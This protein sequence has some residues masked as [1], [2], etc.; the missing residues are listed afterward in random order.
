MMSYGKK[1]CD[2]RRQKGLS[3]SGLAEELGVSR[4]LISRWESDA[5]KP[6]PKNLNK[7]SEFFGV[8]YFYFDEDS[9]SSSSSDDA[10][11]EKLK[12][13]ISDLKLSLNAVTRESIEKAMLIESAIE[14][15]EQAEFIRRKKLTIIILAV[16]TFLSAFF[17]AAIGIIVLPYQN[18]E[19]SSHV[20]N[21]DVNMYWFV[22]SAI[23]TLVLLAATLCAAFLWR[24]KT[25]YDKA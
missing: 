24:R 5:V 3:Q 12:G 4:I 15:A 14:R 25:L 16:F 17:T 1:I 6:S 19:Y 20:S 7:L 2:L 11:I 21:I 9:S 13:E 18:N 23:I 8:S 22:A 10:A